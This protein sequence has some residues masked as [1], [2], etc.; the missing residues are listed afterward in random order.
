[1]LARF[2]GVVQNLV[3]HEK[4]ML[5]IPTNSAELYFLKKF[6]LNLI[7][8]GLTREEAYRIVQRNALDAFENDG[9]FKANLMKDED[10]TKLLS[11]EE[12]DK[13]FNKEEFL[14]NI[15]TIYKRIL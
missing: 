5:K 12:I 9:D 10:V 8:K 7:E 3:V 6:C 15:E 11:V 13:I 4:N 14:Q 2:N 1:M